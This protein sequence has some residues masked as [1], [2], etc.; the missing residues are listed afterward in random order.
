MTTVRKL[1]TKAYRESGLIG[2][3]ED[4]DA[5]EFEEGLDLLQGLYSSLF[6]NELG[7]PYE[8]VNYGSADLVNAYA[9]EAD[10]SSFID[11]IYVPEN[12]RIIFNITSPGTIYLYPN[13]RDGAR[14]CA[15]DNLDNFSTYPLTV[16]GNGRQIQNAQSVVLNTNG[17][18][19][20]WFY[21]ADLGG[22][23]KITD[24]TADDISPL[25][26]EFD[27][28]LTT[29]VAIRLN[30]RNGAQTDDNIQTILKRAQRQMRARYHQISEQRAEDALIRLPSNKFWRY[31]NASTAFARGRL[32]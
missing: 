23:A 29:A 8:T 7:D 30:P 19:V 9:V 20:E 22:W 11:S 24:L 12:L 13:P 14:L 3:G 2:L 27:D 6:G 5:E 16:N 4:P 10:Q 31:R 28:F 15:I 21:R 25:P 17:S 32:A 18:N 26:R 1:V